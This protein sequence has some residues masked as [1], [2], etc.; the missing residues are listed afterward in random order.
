MAERVLRSPGVTTRELDLSAPGR[1]RPQGIPAGIVGTSEKGPA[2]VPVNFA[3]SNDFL[4]IFG[5]T[6]GKHFGAMAVN[7][8]MRNARSGTYLRVLGIGDGQKSNGSGTAAYVNCVARSGF[9]VGQNI[10]DAVRTQSLADGTYTATIESQGNADRKVV[11][12][13]AG[14][15]VP[16]GLDLKAASAG[17][18]QAGAEEVSNLAIAGVFGAVTDYDGMYIIVNASASNDEGETAEEKRIIVLSSQAVG[19]GVAQRRIADKKLMDGQA[20][21]FDFNALAPAAADSVHLVDLTGDAAI[22]D[23][24]ASIRTFTGDGNNGGV[25][26]KIDALGGTNEN[27]IFTNSHMGAV[28][29]IS[30][31][32]ITGV[33][34][35]P[36]DYLTVTVTTPGVVKVVEE[37]VA[38]TLEFD[39]VP[40]NDAI[41]TVTDHLGGAIKV[42]YNEGG[43]LSTALS[44]AGVIAARV[45]N[46]TTANTALLAAAHTAAI[47]KDGNA[48]AADATVTLAAA[49]V[50]GLAADTLSAFTANTAAVVLSETASRTGFQTDALSKMEVA[51]STPSSPSGRVFFLGAEHYAAGTAQDPNDYLGSATTTGASVPLLR[52]VLM[53]PSGVMPGIVDSD[54]AIDTSTIPSSAFESYGSGLNIG[55]SDLNAKMGTDG[56]FHLV[57][58][59]FDNTANYTENRVLTGSFNP[60]SPIYFPKVLNTDP[61]KIQEK[62]HYL[63]AHYDVPTVLAQWDSKASA[64]HLRK[65][66]YFNGFS[67]SDIHDSSGTHRPTFEDW[68]QRFEHAYT[69]WIISQTLGNTQKKLFKLHM[70]DAGSA[71]H[72]QIKVSIVNIAKSTDRSSDYGTFD[73]QIR[74]AHDT[75]M[76]PEILQQFSGLS[77][78]P[79]SDRYI[80]RVIGDQNTFYDFDKDEGKQ[81]LVTEGLYPN[82][83]QY[84]RVEVNSQ[85]EAGAMEA[86]ALPMGFQGKN[87]LVLDGDAL[88]QN[89]SSADLDLKEPPLPFRTSVSVGSERTK[90]VDSRF[91]WGAQ[92][93]DIRDTTKRNQTSG[94]ISLIDNLT[95][96]YPQIGAFAAWVGDNKGA[97]ASAGGESLDADEYQNN[98]FTLER[99]MI[100]CLD[101]DVSKA[102]DPTQW[103]E[104]VYVRD[105]NGKGSD[106]ETYSGSGASWLDANGNNKTRST[107]TAGNSAG[108]RY[109]DVSKDFGSAASKKYF[110]FTVPVQGGW[111]GL[112]IF[113]ADKAAMN[114]MSAFR[115]MD[116]NTS[117]TYGGPSG[118]T[119]AAFRKALDILAEKSDVDVQLLATP[120][121]RD[122]GITDYAIDKTEDRFD[123]LYVMDM[124]AYDHD[125]NLITTS[126][127]ETSVSQTA[128]KLADRNLDTSFA[129]TYFPDL[130]IQ[131]GANNVV[132]PPS[133]AVLGAL[134][135]NDK[136]AHPWFAPAGFA[137]G[138]LPSTI[139]TAVKLNRTNMDV[140]YESDINP[141]TSFP[142]TGESVIVFG[143]K[144]MLQ[145]QSALDRV[146][147]RRLLIDVRRK[148]RTVANQILFEPNREATLARFSSLVNP[149]LGR[150]QQQQGV[151]RYKVVIDTTTTTQQDVENN[152][153]RGKI[154][155]QPTRSIE[156]ISLD[157]VVTNAGAEI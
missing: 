96:W 152:T 75:D 65:G 17:K 112:D 30:I 141:I 86:S 31:G 13:Y 148:V 90:V 122:A 114:T 40:R 58:N 55:S 91:Y 52:G 35:T 74:S 60:L 109:L 136:V 70:L 8:W 23:V 110:K 97:V 21:L 10:R 12:P 107:S 95:K 5:G 138:A 37:A 84:V 89:G 44:N 24:A 9:Q 128:Q 3:T 68:R 151:D 126:S 134:S 46:T 119:T 93:Q 42:G 94:V 144:T 104:A 49:P 125:G 26:A 79:A 129:A 81:K 45:V 56:E 16:G 22:N 27:V 48:G 72:G 11:N 156:F 105:G 116:T 78:N 83:S 29:D 102:I 145:S 54:A 140:L 135:L 2:F 87:H 142:Q 14:A 73:L 1:V 124:S 123:A 88:E 51:E 100:R 99:V 80:A 111:D 139:E 106:I 28:T 50:N 15:S 33:A 34:G 39:R 146:N 131:D 64:V 150:I 130:V 117:A 76:K 32:K 143:Q 147:V 120:G 66:R 154:F 59:G 118:P 115:E 98:K 53:F 137:R 4:N 121:M 157:F 149:I 69:P 61:T 19:A 155:L 43:T 113:D 132:V 67:G 82:N 71:G 20:V 127:Q 62:G 63:Y 38:Q 108:Y 103:S 101:G 18:I 85:I 57:L 6:E 25:I 77:L 41:L 47:L 7:E 36:S 92:Y 133:V 153:I